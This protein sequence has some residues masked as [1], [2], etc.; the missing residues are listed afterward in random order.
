MN[1]EPIREYRKFFRKR[2]DNKTW[3]T[4]DGN[5][6]PIPMMPHIHLLNSG[7][8]IER[9]ARR[10]VEKQLWEKEE[11]LRLFKS[12][13]ISG[14]DGEGLEKE[15]ERLRSLYKNT[16]ECTAINYP[17]YTQ[18]RDEAIKRGLLETGE[19]IDRACDRFRIS[20]RKRIVKI[21]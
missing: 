14:I 15:T 3:I 6:I 9:D 19:T 8:R 2:P 17:I 11:Q 21:L 18:M 12:G 7:R 1:E 5:I 10:H 16:I 13:K 4:K 20:Q